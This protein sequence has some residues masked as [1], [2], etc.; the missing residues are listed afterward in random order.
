MLPN[1]ITL[2]TILFFVQKLINILIGFI[3]IYFFDLLNN[4]FLCIF[5]HHSNTRTSLARYFQVK[6]LMPRTGK[7]VE[8]EV[9]EKTTSDLE[10][11]L[12]QLEKIWLKDHRFLAGFLH[13]WNPAEDSKVF[14]FRWQ[15]LDCWFELLWRNC[16]FVSDKIWFE[17]TTKVGKLDQWIRKVASLWWSPFN[18]EEGYGSPLNQVLRCIFKKCVVLTFDYLLIFFDSRRSFFILKFDPTLLQKKFIFLGHNCFLIFQHVDKIS[19][20]KWN[21][22]KDSIMND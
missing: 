8:P 22:Q 10:T 16:Q 14:I 2:P 1:T 4:T 20:K 11:T 7:S 6:F 9:A 13:S 18:F 17:E 15:D 19:L 3:Y 12:D 21:N 5:R